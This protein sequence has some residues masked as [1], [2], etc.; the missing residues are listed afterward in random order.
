[1]RGGTFPTRPLAVAKNAKN[2]SRVS[3]YE[4]SSTLA[5]RPIRAPSTPTK[6]SPRAVAGWGKVNTES[7]VPATNPEERPS[8]VF[9]RLVRAAHAAKRSLSCKPIPGSGVS[10]KR[11]T[12]PALM[13]ATPSC[14]SDKLFSIRMQRFSFKPL[15]ERPNINLRKSRL[16]DDPHP[17]PPHKGEG[18]RLIA[19][20]FKKQFLNS[21]PCPLVGRARVGEDG[22]S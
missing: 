1:V 19:L 6:A 10:Y 18:T 15:G 3:R 16:L 9:W 5:F 22:Q 12:R 17:N 14:A 8:S 21:V 7:T 20:I 2:L 4:S 11:N 13:A